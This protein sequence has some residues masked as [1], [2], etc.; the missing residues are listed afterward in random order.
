MS[1]TNKPRYYRRHQYRKSYTTDAKRI[2]NKR[3]RQHVRNRLKI[4]QVDDD[5][6]GYYPSRRRDIFDRWWYD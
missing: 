1:R 3:A 6:E 4:D 5:F 2:G